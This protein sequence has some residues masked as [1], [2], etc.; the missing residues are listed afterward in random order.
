[1]NSKISEK[2][3]IHAIHANNFAKIQK[4]IRKKEA[5]SCGNENEARTTLALATSKLNITS[6]D[7]EIVYEMLV[8]KYSHVLRNGVESI[9]KIYLLHELQRDGQSGSKQKLQILLKYSKNVSVTELENNMLH[10]FANMLQ[11]KLAMVFLIEQLRNY[12]AQNVNTLALNRSVSTIKTTL[13]FLEEYIAINRILPLLQVNRLPRELH[14]LV[15]S[16]LH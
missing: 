6:T 11:R 13:E 5:C 8:N 12:G 7:E 2:K 16:F 3:I 10:P 9:R 1:M 4:L 15:W 14:Q